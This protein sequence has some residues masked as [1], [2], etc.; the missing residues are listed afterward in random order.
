MEVWFL[1]G[2]G[3]ALAGL[4]MAAFAYFTAGNAR[5]MLREASARLTQAMANHDEAAKMYAAANENMIKANAALERAR[6]LYCVAL[7][8]TMEEDDD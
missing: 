2:V 4:A 5:V 7:T 8:A 6:A 1:G 3:F